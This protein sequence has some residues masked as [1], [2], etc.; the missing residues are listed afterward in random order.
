[1]LQKHTSCFC[2]KTVVIIYTQ[3]VLRISKFNMDFHP[4]SVHS[5][6]V[7]ITQL[8]SHYITAVSF[9]LQLDTFDGLN[10]F[11]NSHFAQTCYVKIVIHLLVMIIIIYLYKIFT[12]PWIYITKNMQTLFCRY[13]KRNT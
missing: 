10:T 4:V 7:K 11:C 8:S 9:S 2:I 13:H 6:E 1:M 12:F 5:V 3:F